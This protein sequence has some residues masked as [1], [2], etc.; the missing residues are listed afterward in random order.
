MEEEGSVQGA[1]PSLCCCSCACSTHVVVL[2]LP[3]VLR[4]CVAWMPA[5]PFWRRCVATAIRV[6]VC[7]GATTYGCC[8]CDKDVLGGTGNEVSGEG[9]GRGWCGEKRGA[10]HADLPSAASSLCQHLRGLS[11]WPIVKLNADPV[12]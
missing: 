5:A 9:T 12:P 11:V 2:R 1:A 7:V 3:R 4:G 8:C 10:S 6:C